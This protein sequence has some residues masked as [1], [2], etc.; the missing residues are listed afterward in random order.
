MPRSFVRE[1][2]RERLEAIRRGRG[3]G[4]Q[5]N[6]RVGR[7]QRGAGDRAPLALSKRMLTGGRWG[8]DLGDV[9]VFDLVLERQLD[10]HRYIL[11]A[12]ATF[13]GRRIPGVLPDVVLEESGL[14]RDKS[15]ETRVLHDE[16]HKKGP[17]LPR[18]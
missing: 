16:V 3:Y 10:A 18:G 13:H 7:R 2:R 14:K 8:F 5:P 6:L 11:W 4:W 1:V 17:V 9:A 12:H 15:V